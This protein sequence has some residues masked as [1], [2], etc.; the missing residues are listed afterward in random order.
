MKKGVAALPE[1]R[2]RHFGGVGWPVAGQLLALSV[3]ARTQ[4]AMEY[5]FTQQ[6]LLP[7]DRAN[8]LMRPTADD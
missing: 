8:S 5:Q 1:G 2:F 7:Q 3:G 6:L 4:L